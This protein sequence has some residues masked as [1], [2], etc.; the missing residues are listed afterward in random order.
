MARTVRLRDFVVAG[1]GSFPDE[2]LAIA[3]AAN[4]MTEGA[5]YPT[6]LPPFMRPPIVQSAG[7][8]LVGT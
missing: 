3:G 7:P 5:A 8:P 4:V 1:K 6:D 2:M